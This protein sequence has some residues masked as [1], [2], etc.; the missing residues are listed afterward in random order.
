MGFKVRKATHT[1]LIFP[2]LNPQSYKK[3][4]LY[5]CFIGVIYLF[6]TCFSGVSCLK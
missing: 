3:I 5:R 1:F 2:V 6:F 4:V